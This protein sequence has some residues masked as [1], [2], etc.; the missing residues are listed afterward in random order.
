MRHMPP[1]ISAAKRT[2]ERRGASEFGPGPSRNGAEVAPQVNRDHRDGILRDRADLGPRAY[3]Q[4][5]N[6]GDVDSYGN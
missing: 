6:E 2:P 1:E 5:G 4:T 3:G